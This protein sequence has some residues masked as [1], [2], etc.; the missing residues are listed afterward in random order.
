MADSSERSNSITQPNPSL[1]SLVPVPISPLL[2]PNPEITHPFRCHRC[3]KRF[4]STHA[5]GGHQNAH[6]KERSEERRLQNEK[7]LGL[8]RQKKQQQSQITIPSA[9]VPL[10]IVQPQP[11]GGANTAGHLALGSPNTGGH[12]ALGSANTGGGHLALG[13]ANPGGHLALGGANPGGQL[14]LG[15]ANPV[16]H[17]ALGSANPGGHLALGSA[18]PGI[19]LSQTAIVL[20]N[21]AVPTHS[22][23]LMQPLATG[24]IYGC[25]QGPVFVP[26]A[27]F[28]PT[29]A[30]VIGGEVPYKAP[31]HQPAAVN[32]TPIPSELYHREG[33]G[34]RE[35]YPASTSTDAAPNAD[36]PLTTEGSEGTD[37]NASKEEELDLTLRL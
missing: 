24:F 29:G 35:Y 21:S 22:A 6:K 17:L 30:Q 9:P 13:S 1:R 5:L 3:S 16:G 15:S 14:A 20:T 34:S 27:G 33:A 37:Q 12:L 36:E 10:S 26:A 4:T 19:H 7:R 28:G 25:A 31:H 18:N 2:S 32:T 8:T 23:I 11:N